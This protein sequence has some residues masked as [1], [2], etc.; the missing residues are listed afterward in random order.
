[1]LLVRGK[2]RLGDVYGGLDSPPPGVTQP[3]SEPGRTF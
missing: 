2:L 1:M 3:L